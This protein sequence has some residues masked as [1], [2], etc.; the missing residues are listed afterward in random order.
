MTV[1]P[2]KA[3]KP[4]WRGWVMLAGCFLGLCTIFALVVTASEAWKEHA[5]AQW[6]E[7]TARIQSCGIR[8]SRKGYSGP[9]DSGGGG[10]YIRCRIGYQ[11]GAE[12]PTADIFS[13][14]VRAPNLL[15]RQDPFAAV[16]DLQA[17][18]ETHP[19]G[20]PLEVHYDPSHHQK[21]ALVVTD[22]PGGGPRTPNNLKLLAGF[23]GAC[24]ALLAMARLGRP[25]Y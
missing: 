5:Q 23:A 1:E 13:T 8:V 6:P 14:S 20:T 24:V 22:M 17:W 10:Y 18:V 19:P 16:S 9:F 15:N 12:E 2:S 11:V 4:G 21:A 3:T 25:S 7:V